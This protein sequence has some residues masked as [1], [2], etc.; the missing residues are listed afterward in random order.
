MD[1]LTVL[2]TTSVGQGI[3][4]CFNVSAA[5]ETQRLAQAFATVVKMG[6]AEEWHAGRIKPRAQFQ[7]CGTP[8]TIA[9]YGLAGD[10][11]STFA[12]ALRAELTAG[13]DS[14]NQEFEAILGNSRQVM[15]WSN[16]ILTSAGVQVRS[17]DQYGLWQLRNNNFPD[18]PPLPDRIMPG[19]DVVEKNAA[20]QNCM[21]FL[22]K[23]QS[24]EQVKVVFEKL[25][26]EVD[27]PR[28]LSVSIMQGTEARVAFDE[29]IQGLGF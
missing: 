29:L 10:G 11:K 20:W 6:F 1:G 3:S 24:A 15:L 18:L 19:I 21:G 25:G 4:A 17:F 14:E 23:A 7:N 9:L 13:V 12:R 16:T 27:A 5:T 26:S 2:T 28:N 8:F 22:P